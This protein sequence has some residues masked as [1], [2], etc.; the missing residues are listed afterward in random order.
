MRIAVCDDKAAQNACSRNVG[1]AEGALAATRIARRAHDGG[2]GTDNESLFHRAVSHKRHAG[3]D[4]DAVL[5]DRIPG[6][7]LVIHAFGCV[8]DI[9]RDDVLIR[10][11]AA[12]RPLR[13]LGREAITVVIR[14]R[15]IH[16]PVRADDDVGD[17][18]APFRLA[19]LRRRIRI[20]RARH[21]LSIDD[22]A[23]G[24]TLRIDD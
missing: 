10:H 13:R 22:K 3:L 2:W 19:D 21:E 12:K 4:A 5:R 1:A 17:V 16:V 23:D 11:H 7:P 24:G 20:G 8:D 6:R 15:R 9:A 14:H 18:H